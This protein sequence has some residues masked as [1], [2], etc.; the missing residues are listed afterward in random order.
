MGSLWGMLMIL[1][2][3][4]DPLHQSSSIQAL[5]FQSISSALR[6]K[7]FKLSDWQRPTEIVS[8][9]VHATTGVQ[10]VQLLACFHALGDHIH[11]ERAAHRDECTYNCGI[12]WVRCQI[13][14]KGLINLHLAQRQAFE[15]GQR[16]LELGEKMRIRLIARVGS[17]MTGSILVRLFCPIVRLFVR[18]IGCFPRLFPCSALTH[19]NTE[20]GG[21]THGKR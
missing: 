9:I 20:D 13:A 17:A 12:A 18:L 5:T 6:N 21:S 4:T 1:I 10:E 2:N 14:Y 19:S 8:L 16:L 11:T 3:L 15:V 7:H